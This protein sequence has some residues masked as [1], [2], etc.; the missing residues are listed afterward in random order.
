[1]WIVF[2]RAIRWS[3]E[4]EEVVVGVVVGVMEP[5]QHQPCRVLYTTFD[6]PTSHTYVTGY[7]TGRKYSLKDR[8][9]G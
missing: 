6:P 2:H 4:V 9:V 1:M 7:H 3:V 5:S 8:L